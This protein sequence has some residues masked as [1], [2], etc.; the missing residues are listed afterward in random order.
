MEVRDPYGSGSLFETSQSYYIDNPDTSVGGKV[1]VTDA[2][3]ND[4]DI[5]NASRK[6][7]LFYMMMELLLTLMIRYIA[8]EFEIRIIRSY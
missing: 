8:F 6:V 2:S 1:R 4:F 3:G 5:L 7:D